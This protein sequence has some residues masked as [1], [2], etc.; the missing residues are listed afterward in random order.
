MTMEKIKRFGS[1]RFCGQSRMVEPLDPD[2]ATQD[3]LDEMAT[4]SCNCRE[5]RAARDEKE[6]LEA[7]GAYIEQLSEELMKG[8]DAGRVDALR[9]AMV[10]AAHIVWEEVADNIAF[11]VNG[12]SVKIHRTVDKIKFKTSWSCSSEVE[13]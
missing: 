8:E 9:R 13:F 1:C 4:A 2:T 3:D 11:K 6:Q 7:A 10:T 12:K 5:A